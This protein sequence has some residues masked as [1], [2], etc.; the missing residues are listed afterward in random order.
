MPPSVTFDDSRHDDGHTVNTS[1]RVRA[2]F[3]ERFRGYA[4]ESVHR[5]PKESVFGEIYYKNYWILTK[6][7]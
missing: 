7:E 6:P 1:S 2:W 4:L 3:L 5:E